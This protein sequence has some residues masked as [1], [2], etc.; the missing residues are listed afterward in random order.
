MFTNLVQLLG[1]L[2]GISIAYAWYYF[3]DKKDQRIL[4]ELAKQHKADLEA[5]KSQI[6]KR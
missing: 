4:E 6:L 5:I 2:F 1:G 3:D